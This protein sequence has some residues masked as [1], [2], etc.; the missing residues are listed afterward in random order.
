LE[1][2]TL[3]NIETNTKKEKIE[4]KSQELNNVL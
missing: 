2:K 4:T 3:D 1:L